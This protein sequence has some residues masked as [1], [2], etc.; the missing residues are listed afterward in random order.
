MVNINSEG[1]LVTKETLNLIVNKQF[2][3]NSIQFIYYDTILQ[4]QSIATLPIGT[5]YLAKTL[6][7]YIFSKS[8]SITAEVDG[9]VLLKC[10][11]RMSGR[12]ELN[13][14]MTIPTSAHKNRV[15]AKVEVVPSWAVV[16]YNESVR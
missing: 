14:S 3:K 5:S 10:G 7:N 12:I 4:T 1:I 11:G 9:I 6:P 8:H 13:A 2:L 16:D 15:P